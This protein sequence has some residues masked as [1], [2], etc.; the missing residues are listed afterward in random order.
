MKKSVLILT[1]LVMVSMISGCFENDN[2][3]DEEKSI[4]SLQAAAEEQVE[5]PQ[6]NPN[7]IDV[8][9]KKNRKFS[10]LEQ[11][12]LAKQEALISYIADKDLSHL[13]DFTPEEMVLAYLYGISIGDPDFIYTITYNGGKLPDPDE[14]RQDYF[15]YEMNDDAETALKYRFYDSIKVDDSTAKENNVTV[16]ITVSVESFTHSLALGLQKE[17]RIW[18]LD[19]YHLMELN[20]NKTTNEVH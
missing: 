11:L 9:K 18:K 5:V 13:Y 6:T 20:K 16:L 10:Y 2:S 15:K 7:N 3:R 8:T 14:F 17:D 12:P 4:T 1:A 19:V